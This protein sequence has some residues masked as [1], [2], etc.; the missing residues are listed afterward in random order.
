[1]DPVWQKGFQM[2]RNIVLFILVAGLSGTNLSTAADADDLMTRMGIVGV[3]GKILAPDFKT[4]DIN[5]HPVQLSDFRGKM[6]MLFFWAT[7]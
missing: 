7:W 1:M 6:V 5:G 4:E 3:T 2:K